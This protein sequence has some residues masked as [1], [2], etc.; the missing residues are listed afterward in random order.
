MAAV[1]LSFVRPVKRARGGN[2][3]AA[4]RARAAP[5]PQHHANPA[6]WHPAL[7]NKPDRVLDALAQSGGMLGFSLYPHHLKGGSDCTLAAFCEMV[8]RTAERMGTDRL[9]IGSDLCQDQPDS[10]VDWM[11]AGR[12]TKRRDYGEGNADNPGFPP[13]R[14]RSVMTEGAKGEGPFAG[15]VGPDD[16]LESVIAVSGGDTGL[17]YR[18]MR[19]GRQVGVLDMQDLVRALVP[20]SAA[21]DGMRARAV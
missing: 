21:D 15:E 7:R 13:M 12:W 19:E 1:L 17:S 2:R 16:T 4:D 8:A 5:L 20:T 6:G 9:G 3:G 14:V 11:R 18:V 10:V